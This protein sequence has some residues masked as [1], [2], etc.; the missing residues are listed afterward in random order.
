MLE[1]GQQPRV[2]LYYVVDRDAARD[3][4][5]TIL[6]QLR[7]TPPAIALVTDIRDAEMAMRLAEQVSITGQEIVESLAKTIALE[8]KRPAVIIGKASTALEAV[9]A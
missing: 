4:E 1:E 6:A 7:I 2:P 5:D 8:L 9:Y 3:Q